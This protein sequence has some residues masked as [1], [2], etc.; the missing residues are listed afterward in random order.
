MRYKRLESALFHLLVIFS[1]ILHATH[2]LS[3]STWFT[4]IGDLSINLITLL[5]YHIA[6]ISH[7]SH[8]MKMAITLTWYSESVRHTIS[9][10]LR[11]K[12]W[13]FRSTS[14]LC[15]STLEPNKS[16]LCICRFYRAE[17][18]G[19]FGGSLGLGTENEN[20]WEL[21]S[22]VAI[23]RHYIFGLRSLTEFTV[24]HYPETLARFMS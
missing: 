6:I 14:T 12:V 22:T 13:N 17:Q 24:P 20:C 11:V 2:K 8:M 19:D 10:I 3:I 1:D 16:Q 9:T 7:D 23:P 15:G 21:S 4:I 18:N 5:S